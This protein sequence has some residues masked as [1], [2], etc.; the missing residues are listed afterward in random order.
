M[1]EKVWIPGHGNRSAGDKRYHTDRDCTHF[2]SSR[3]VVDRELIEAWGYT[4]CAFCSGE[5]AA[6]H[7]GQDHVKSLIAWREENGT[8]LP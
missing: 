5:W 6:S 3:T 2:P 1:T 7:A 8:E 4:E